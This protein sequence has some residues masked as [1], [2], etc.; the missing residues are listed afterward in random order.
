MP[1]TYDERLKAALNDLHVVRL[2][3][4]L[5]DDLDE[6]FARAGVEVVRHAVRL[7]LKAALDA[8]EQVRHIQLQATTA[9]R[10]RI[11][12]VCVY[13]VLLFQQRP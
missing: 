9:R 6:R 1:G 13:V 8:Q 10:Q 7:V 2:Q 11:R 12:P 3:Q 4:V 5:F